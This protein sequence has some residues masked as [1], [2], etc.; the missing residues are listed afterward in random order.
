MLRFLQ[1]LRERAIGMLNTGMT[2][3][4]VATNIVCS[5]RAIRHLRQRF[6]AI[7]HMEDQS[8]SGRPRVMTRGQNRYTRN[9]RLRDRFQ[10][11]TATAANTHGT[12]NN[13]ISAQSLAQGLVHVVH[14]LVVFW[15]KSCNSTRP[16][17]CLL[18]QQWNS[19]PFSK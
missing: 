8:R 1:D 4:A 19:V 7:G 12:H 15:R 10:T 3:N 6:Q 13:R 14:L 18:R 17:Q 11:A 16:H 2:M 9:I 5:I